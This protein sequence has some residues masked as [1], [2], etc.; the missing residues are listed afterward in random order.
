MALKPVTIRLDEEEYANLKD[1]LDKFGDPDI[2]I[3]FVIRSYIRDLNRAMPLIMKS[4]WDLKNYFGLLGAWLKQFGSMTDFEVL[5]KTM[6]NPW[7][8][9][10][11]PNSPHGRDDNMNNSSDKKV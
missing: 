8:F 7:S 3:A 4:D 10:Q 5:S 9:W 11:S 2:N 1:Y 6:V